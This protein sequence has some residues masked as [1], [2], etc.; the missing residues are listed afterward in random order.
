[1]RIDPETAITVGDFVEFI[2]PV[3]GSI[4]V[5]IVISIVKKRRTH[6]IQITVEDA[7][8]RRLKITHRDILKVVENDQC[9]P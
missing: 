9:P 5:Q 4:N 6:R 8:G 3:R 2:H 7:A 1:M